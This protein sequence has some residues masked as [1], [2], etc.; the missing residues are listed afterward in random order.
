MNQKS[1]QIEFYIVGCMFVL[2][3][4]VFF[5]FLCVPMPKK[6]S[7]PQIKIVSTAYFKIQVF[8]KNRSINEGK[9][10]KNVVILLCR[11]VQSKQFKMAA[12]TI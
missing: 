11:L 12:K 6:K 9:A 4:G 7:R 2:K 3:T 1:K 5:F 10:R 8:R